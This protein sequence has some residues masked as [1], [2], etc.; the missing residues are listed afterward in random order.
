MLNTN[1]QKYLLAQAFHMENTSCV[2]DKDDNDPHLVL[3]I[4]CE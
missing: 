1:Y 2:W 3:Q 4:I